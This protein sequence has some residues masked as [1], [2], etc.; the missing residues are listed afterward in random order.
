MCL[1]RIQMPD[2]SILILEYMQKV[3]MSLQN[4]QVLRVRPIINLIYTY[5]IGLAICF[6]QSIIIDIQHVT[7]AT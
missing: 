7:M 3:Q 5:I 2:K 4:S 6:P 1:G